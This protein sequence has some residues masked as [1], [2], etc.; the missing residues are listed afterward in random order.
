MCKKTEGFRVEFIKN[1]VF[2]ATI[3]SF[4]ETTYRFKPPGAKQINALDEVM[5]RGFRLYSS[6][7][8]PRGS[9]KTN[10][11]LLNKQQKSLKAH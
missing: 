8:R 7:F 9:K 2:Q 3:G 4:V 1:F 6:L 10:I 11:K 5:Q